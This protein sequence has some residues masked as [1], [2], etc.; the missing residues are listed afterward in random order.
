MAVDGEI[1]TWRYNV[2]P[3]I[4]AW[5][6]DGTMGFV[7]DGTIDSHADREWWIS[8]VGEFYRRAGESATH[9]PPS[10]P[11][12]TEVALDLADGI[13][14]RVKS[15]L[16]PAS[17]HVAADYLGRD[18][19]GVELMGAVDFSLVGLAAAVDSVRFW[20]PVTQ[21]H[22]EWNTIRGGLY[23]RLDS[24]RA[25]YEAGLPRTHRVRFREDLATIAS[26]HG[27]SVTTL[28]NL[29]RLSVFQEVSSGQELC[30]P[31]IPPDEN[32]ISTAAALSE[33]STGTAA[34]VGQEVTLEGIEV[35]SLLGTQA[36]W[37]NLDNG[38]PY[39]LHLTE[40]ALAD[41]V[42]VAQGDVVTVNGT[43][44]EMSDSILDAWAAA[45]AFSQETDRIQAEF[46][47][48]FLEVT[49]ISGGAVKD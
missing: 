47:V 10:D 28:R 9:C 16:P 44:M 27:I 31:H 20:C 3:E 25:A 48:D 5:Y 24:L 17:D 39:L 37:M 45:G 12:L 32:G 35:V 22:Q 36:L 13:V 26:D 43:V 46:A 8:E 15:W 29:N 4:G 2:T 33:F 23:R 30:V 41:S 42:A 40:M 7:P 1:L 49:S 38:T 11:Y 34:Y 6:L 19:L 18:E 14:D 21:S